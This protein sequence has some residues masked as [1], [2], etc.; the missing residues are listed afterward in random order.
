[1]KNMMWVM[2]LNCAAL[3]A[4]CGSDSG[5]SNDADSA[6]SSG[7]ALSSGVAGKSSSSAYMDSTALDTLP[8]KAISDKSVS[9]VSQKGP[10]LNGSSV[11]LQELDGKTL[12][13]TG[14]SFKGKISG[15]KGEFS[16]SSVTLASQYALL[17]ANGYYKNEVTGNN[18][19]GTLTLDALTDL[20]DRANVNINLLTHLEYERA[21]YLA[22]EK[23]YNVPAAKKQASA[24]VLA[25]F[26]IAGD[27][28][29]SED[30]SIFADG[31]GDAAL[32]ALSVMLQGDRSEAELSALLADFSADIEKDGVWDAAQTKADIADWASSADL[33]AIR[34][35]VEG[36]KLSAVVPDFEK[37]VNA[38]WENA[39]GLGSCTDANEGNVK[40][41]TNGLSK[42]YKAYYA[43]DSSVWRP[44]SRVEIKLNK[45][46]VD[47]TEGDTMTYVSKWTCRSGVWTWDTDKINKGSFTYGGQT[48]K[49]V[50]VGFQVW[51]A[52]NLNYADSLALP[53]L[54]GRSS[55]Y[56]DSPDSCAKYGRL[57]TWTGAMNLDSSYVATL[58][59]AVI[60]IPHQG[61]CPAGWH[62]PTDDEWDELAEAVGG[63]S[64]AGTKLKSKAGWNGSGNGT[65]DYG[66]SVLPAGYRYSNGDFIYAGYYADFWSAT[67]D[68]A[69]NAYIRYL[70]FSLAYMYSGIDYKSYAFSVRCVQD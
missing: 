10:F 53:N 63:A 9:G 8:V 50:A 7:A 61:V 68:G 27:F 5:S 41:D 18:S 47:K 19:T 46:C 15:D 28:G 4:A 31:E 30:L 32:L 45:A 67:E 40:Q 11:T 43:C 34:G 13:Q 52:E 58:A 17:E 26:G 36:W 6:L 62:I 23:G 37:Y 59:S 42:N 22:R 16:V 64:S 39:Y 60:K 14:K 2:A 48:Y 35:N 38:Y 25:A 66:F 70:N 1:M 69:N 21:L 56:G 3:L 24:E 29:N 55:C 44:A 51:M 12:A 49:T 54:K 57:Y 20:S 33:S 65:D